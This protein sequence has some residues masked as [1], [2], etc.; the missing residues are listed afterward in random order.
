MV[1]VHNCALEISLSHHGICQYSNGILKLKEVCK[2]AGISIP[3]AI[4]KKK[5]DADVADGIAALLERHGLSR[6]SGRGEIA[7]ARSRIQKE[8]ELE[9]RH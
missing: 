3:T 2:K 5:T 8:K 9:G 7:D 1:G 6:S 4:Y